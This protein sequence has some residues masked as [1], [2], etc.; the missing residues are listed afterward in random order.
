MRSPML[1]AGGLLVASVLAAG[2][3]SPAEAA[4]TARGDVTAGVTV[5]GATLVHAAGPTPRTWQGGLPV[6]V[7]PR[8][9]P[10]GRSKPSAPWNPAWPKP[11]MFK[12]T[13]KGPLSGRVIALDPGHDIGNASHT[14]QINRKY[15]VGLSKICNTTGTATN[16]GYAE[17]SYAFDVAARLRRL[18]TAQGATVILTRDRNTRDTWGPCIGARGTLAAQEGAELMVAVHADGGPASGRGFHVIGPA[19]YKGYTDDIYVGSKKLAKA[20]VAGM[21]S[22]GLPRSTYL[23]STIR[24]LKDTGAINVSDVPTITVET[25]NMRN[26]ADAARAS[27]KAGRQK[28]AK[29]L[30][31]GIVRYLRTA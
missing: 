28:V 21:V 12:P 11:V 17:S 7:A 6:P 20:M 10:Q 8:W 4:T 18:L 27:S 26:R 15:W 19:Y 25:L 22:Q 23:S 24:L 16:A 31:V 29:G 30:Y 1:L 9:W 13:A 5:S 3:V 14:R 2:L